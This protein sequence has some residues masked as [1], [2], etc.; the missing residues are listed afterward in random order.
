MRKS[1]AVVLLIF[2]NLFWAGNYICGKFVIDEME[3]IQINFL[4]WL[5]AAVI[6][7]PLA[8]LIERP[9]WKAIFKE[10]KLLLVLSILPAFPEY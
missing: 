3:P 8:Q 2:A 10:W 4:R 1:T 7:F 5:I 6:L 9:G